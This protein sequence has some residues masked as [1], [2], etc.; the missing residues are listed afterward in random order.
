MSPLW[1][2]Q[3]YDKNSICGIT[4]CRLRPGVYKDG[5]KKVTYLTCNHGFY[6]RSLIEWIKNDRHEFP[7]CPNCRGVINLKLNFSGSL[8]I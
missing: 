3:K 5:M 2:K 4:Q 8:F 7:T 6:T 1:W